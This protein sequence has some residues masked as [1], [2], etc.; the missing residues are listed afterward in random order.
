MSNLHNVEISNNI[1]RKS[2]NLNKYLK[3]GL[4]SNTYNNNNYNNNFN[5]TAT[6]TGAIG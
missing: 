1:I 4:E 6:A 3:G 5:A 2:L